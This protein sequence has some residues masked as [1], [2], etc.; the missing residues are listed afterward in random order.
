MA[1][2]PCSLSLAFLLLA[3]CAQTTPVAPDEGGAQTNRPNVVLIYGDDV[4]Y[5]DLGV[6]GA[7]K[8]PTPNLDA[9]AAEGLRFTDGHCEA[10]T[11]T[12]SRFSLL[13]GV[14]AF[15]HGVRVLPPNAPSTIE[16]GTFTL[17]EMFRQAG[18]RTA[19]VGKWHLGLGAKGT[20]VD[21]NGEVSPGP[22]DLG[23]DESF[24]L[25]S[26][27]DRVPCVYLD[28]RRV[29]GLD[30]EDPLYVGK[31][32]PAGFDGTVYPH[33]KEDR[34][35]MTYYASTQGHADSVIGGIGRIGFQW[36]GQS[37]LWNDETM[38]DVFV[39]RAK[40][41]LA[42][43]SSKDSGGQPFFLY[44]SSQDIH[45]PRTPHPRFRGASDLGYRG[46]AMVQL[47]WAVGQILESLD[48]Q[49]LR[50]NTIV[51]FSSDNG[52]VYDDGY[53]DGT[54]VFTSR[55][56]VDRGHDGSGPFRGGKYQIYEGGT[57][58]PFLVR[59]PGEVEPGVSDAMVNQIDFL[60]SF[61]SMLGVEIPEGQAIDSRDSMEALLG[62][63]PE[64]LSFMLEEA[65]RLAIRT[66]RHKFIRGR[67]PDEVGEL[68]D[69]EVDPG[70]S[71]NLI[72]AQPEIAEDLHTLL[73]RIVEDPEGMRGF[74]RG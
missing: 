26:T 58:V 11:C 36:G 63:D 27:N 30:P 61:A 72:E 14:H 52:P 65:R 5:A 23:F 1:T 51:I 19:V 24:L 73:D 37:A 6:Y 48:E 12:P 41:F 46:D 50:E 71:D 57:R 15:R 64:G 17:P 34:A 25:P 39:D 10:A 2:L 42:R 59:W 31:E 68:Y 9:L 18:Y 67:R 44:F 66:K 53:D 21:W 33:G 49:G 8:I 7:T 55:E 13:T 4:G 70:E 32:P 54:T 74:D 35:A 16:P 60:A 29:A 45:V 40:D 20:P 28:G 22:L 62:Q 47:D 69:L 43:Q 38:A 3:G 56:E